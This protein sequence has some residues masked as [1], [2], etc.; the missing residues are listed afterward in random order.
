MNKD[1]VQNLSQHQECRICVDIPL[2]TLSLTHTCRRLQNYSA[3]KFQAY[4]YV[5]VIIFIALYIKI[6][7]HVNVYK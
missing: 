3:N 7:Q 6:E 4:I 5:S 2:E 1:C